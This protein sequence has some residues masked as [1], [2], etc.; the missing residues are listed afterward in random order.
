MR[1][2]LLVLLA[3]FACRTD[4]EPLGED[5]SPGDDPMALPEALRPTGDEFMVAVIP[6]TQIYAMS[7]PETFDR[8]MKW[9]ADHA[10]AYR[11]VF[12]SHVG[13]IVQH[14]DRR[15]QWAVARA[16][17]DWLD[18]LDIP[19]GFSVAGHDV[20]HGADGYPFAHD[21]DCS[22]FANTDCDATLYRENFGPQH[23]QD[24]PWFL[25]TSPSEQSN[26]QRITVDDMDLLFLHLPQDAPRA[27]V[28]WAHEILDAHPGTLAHLTTHRYLFDYRLTDALP[29]PLDL[30]P[31]GRFNALTYLLGGQSVMYNTG[32]TANEIFEELVSTHPN[33]W[34][35]QCGHVDAE[36]Q[37]PDV[38]QAG[39]PVQQV[40][41]NFQDM[42]DG[43]GGWLRLLR[44][45]PS[46]NQVDV[47]TFSTETG[48]LRVN[49][50]GFEHSLDI[51]DRYKGQAADTLSSL[52]FS[53]DEAD[54][55]LEEIRQGGA[56]ADLYYDS[57]YGDGSRDSQFTLD[58]DFQAYIR[59]SR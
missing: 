24:R 10:E 17:Y 52:G 30:L 57:L 35:V 51:L 40:L 31:A 18:D 37:V 43:G 8:H 14:A 34:T 39:L 53:L 11:I 45:R 20:G 54:A 5:A 7:F 19:H 56:L 32:L 15:D 2:V 33:I 25:G 23:Y 29:P 16:S 42:A 6:D 1:P 13:D 36:F 22:V 26:A 48:E 44:Y 41:V 9:L 49:G 28:D 47:I 4:P 12:V 27:E 58:V 59:A 55:L 50:E 46:D 38:N 21:R 3:T